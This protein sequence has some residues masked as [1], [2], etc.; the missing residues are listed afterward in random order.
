LPYVLP[1]RTLAAARELEH[2]RIEPLLAGPA[3]P[4]GLAARPTA[5][6]LYLGYAAAF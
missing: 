1:P 2:I 4:S 6:G 3:G 5:A